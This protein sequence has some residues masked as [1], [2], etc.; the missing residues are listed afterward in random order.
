MHFY[1]RNS[2]SPISL[3]GAQ[4]DYPKQQHQNQTKNCRSCLSEGKPHESDSCCASGGFAA[5]TGLTV[6]FVDGA[7]LR[8]LLA[9][10][11]KS[12]NRTDSR[13]A[14]YNADKPNPEQ[15]QQDPQQQHLSYW[16]VA[17]LG[18]G[19]RPDP[20]PS[21][22]ASV[23]QGSRELHAVFS[24]KYRADI[25][26]LLDAQ[27]SPLTRFLTERRT[28]ILKRLMCVVSFEGVVPDSICCVNTSLVLLLLT[29]L[30]GQLADTLK[31]IK[32]QFKEAEAE[33]VCGKCPP[34]VGPLLQRLMQDRESGGIQPFQEEDEVSLQ[35]R[36]GIGITNFWRLLHF[37]R[38]HY[39]RRRKDA[40]G[41]EFAC[42]IP[43]HYWHELV[44]ILCGPSD[45]PTS[46]AYPH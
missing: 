21:M 9:R 35:Q 32:K 39:I 38:V 28:E 20:S 26:L 10:G 19:L 11:G 31:D 6:P 2:C 16:D 34:G 42:Q 17:P 15:K 14:K 12:S 5:P 22:V 30:D 7:S 8:N 18:L 40:R 46:L 41:L 29:L 37:W 13:I 45:E 24:G 3:H 36:M 27:Q 23:L 4:D 33:L 43:L 25:H 1:D 44:A